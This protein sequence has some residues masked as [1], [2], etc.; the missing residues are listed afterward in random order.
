MNRRGSSFASTFGSML[1]RAE[2]PARKASCENCPRAPDGAL[3]PSLTSSRPRGRS[4]AGRGGG[5]LG[6]EGPP[7]GE[8]GALTRRSAER[9]SLDGG[10][11]TVGQGAADVSGEALAPDVAQRAEPVDRRRVALVRH[12]DRRPRAV[13]DVVEQVFERRADEDV[14]EANPL[15]PPATDPVDVESRDPYAEPAALVGRDRG[16]RL[17]TAAERVVPPPSPP[18]REEPD[19]GAVGVLDVHRGERDREILSSHRVAAHH[20]PAHAAHEEELGVDAPAELLGQVGVNH[21]GQLL[22]VDAADGAE[23]PGLQLRELPP[24]RLDDR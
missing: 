10:G 24:V 22:L 3:F 6:V 9:D 18:D 8:R 5:I 4:S 7:R 17:A 11:H 20:L 21:A 19:E 1:R 12:L 14:G 2:T 15:G 16:D 13:H 23:P